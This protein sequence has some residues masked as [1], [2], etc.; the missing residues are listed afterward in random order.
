METE[1]RRFRRGFFAGTIS[2]ELLFLLCV[3]ASGDEDAEMTAWS[4]LLVLEAVLAGEELIV[5]GGGGGGGG[6]LREEAGGGGGGFRLGGGGG[7]RRGFWGGRGRLLGAPGGGGG[8]GRTMACVEVI[9]FLRATRSIVSRLLLACRVVQVASLLQTIQQVSFLG[10]LYAVLNRNRKALDNKVDGRRKEVAPER[11][12]KNPP[13]LSPYLFS[14]DFFCL[15]S[16][17]V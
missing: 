8:G 10:F 17:T 13:S 9:V 2:Q 11:S 7:G 16:T 1:S 4:R 12:G 3:V 5:R 14:S 6:D 15:G